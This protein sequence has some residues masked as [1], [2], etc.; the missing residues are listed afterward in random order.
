MQKIAV[1]KAMEAFKKK[2]AEEEKQRQLMQIE[3]DKKRKV[4][5]EQSLKAAKAAKEAKDKAD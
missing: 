1:E 5:V 3:A 2:Q 4:A